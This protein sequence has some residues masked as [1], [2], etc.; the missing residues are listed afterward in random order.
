MNEYPPISRT[1]ATSGRPFWLLGIA[2]LFSSLA[3]GAD[4][5]HFHGALVAEPCVVAPG[6][7]HLTL[8]FGNVVG[9]YLYQNQRSPSQTV[10]LHLSQCDLSVAKGLK[11]TFSGTPNPVLPGLLAL[12]P[13]SQARGIAIGLETAEGRPWP[14]NQAGAVQVL[15]PGANQINVRAYLQGEPAAL[16]NRSIKEGPFTAVAT[17]RLDYE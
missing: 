8:D 16:A 5:M 1:R 17:F 4:N 12:E 2:L 10:V 9:K 13:G 14:L 15:V 7:E 6:D 11:V 3:Q